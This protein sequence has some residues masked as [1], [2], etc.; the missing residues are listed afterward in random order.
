MINHCLYF[1]VYSK[2]F[3]LRAKQEEKHEFLS[4]AAAAAAA[5]GLLFGA[6][7]DSA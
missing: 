6:V 5:F 3:S 1:V 7:H 2:K 4:A